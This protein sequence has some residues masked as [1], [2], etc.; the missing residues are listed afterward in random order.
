MSET[1]NYSGQLKVVTC[2][3]GCRHAVPSELHDYQLRQH[4]RGVKYSIYCPHGHSYIQAGESRSDKLQRELTRTMQRLDQVLADR[5]NE[6]SARQAV[7]RQLTAQQA[8]T[9]RIR[10]RVQNGVCPCCNRHFVNLE[11]HMQTKHPEAKEQA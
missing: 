3:C 8:A 9:K 11:R 1:I 10:N 5:N 2:W 7:Q 6:R 4:D